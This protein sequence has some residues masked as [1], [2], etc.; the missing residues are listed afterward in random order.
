MSRR[1]QITISGLNLFIVPLIMMMLAVFNTLLTNI[2]ERT[3]EVKILS[4]VGVSPSSV[5][6]M[7]IAEA[8]TFAFVSSFTGYI[9][10]IGL[11]K[12]FSSI[13]GFL[14]AGFTPNYSAGIVVVAIALLMMAT[15]IA[16]VYPALKAGTLVTPS[17]ERKW[18]I[19]TKPLGGTW[20][21]PLPLARALTAEDT[22]LSSSP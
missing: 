9:I 6:F 4:A 7:F 13:P 2:Y 1:N 10:G 8:M 22:L 16:S 20:E 21:I 5:T 19:P 11:I 15:L 14:Q 17:L 18:K 12:L 3:R